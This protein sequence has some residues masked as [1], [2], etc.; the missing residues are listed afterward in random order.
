MLRDT[1]DY[2]ETLAIADTGN[3]LP[4]NR[5]YLEQMMAN[6]IEILS[7]AE[8]LQTLIDNAEEKTR[9][10]RKSKLFRN[11]FLTLTLDDCGQKCVFNIDHKLL[12]AS[13]SITI[14]CPPIFSYKLGCQKNIDTLP[15][16]NK[17]WGIKSKNSSVCPKDH[18]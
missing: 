15:I 13:C 2:I 1:L 6:N 8:K 17:L 11:Q 16:A 12:V 5:K 3:L 7:I 18:D 4:T 9:I 10:K 14:K